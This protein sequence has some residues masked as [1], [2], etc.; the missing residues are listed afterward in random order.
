MCLLNEYMLPN[1]CTGGWEWGD[2]MGKG[3]DWAGAFQCCGCQQDRSRRPQLSSLF[4]AHDRGHP[5]RYAKCLDSW[6]ITVPPINTIHSVP[7]FQEPNG[8]CVLDWADITL[9]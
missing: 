5:S 7:T 1:A 9:A 8:S 4:P 3:E 6:L 2:K